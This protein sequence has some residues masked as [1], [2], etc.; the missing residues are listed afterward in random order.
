MAAIDLWTAITADPRW[1]T[2]D[3][4]SVIS[5][6][7]YQR[8]IRFLSPDLQQRSMRQTAVL[9][10]VL[11]MTLNCSPEQLRFGR[12]GRGKPFLPDAPHINF[13]VSHSGPVVLI[14]VTVLKPIGVDVEAIRPMDD[15]ET[16][17]R[18]IFAPGETEAILSVDDRERVLAFFRCWTRKEALVKALGDGLYRD[19]DSFEVSTGP[20][21]VSPLLR[22][23]D[24]DPNEWELHTFWSESDYVAAVAVKSPGSTL[25]M[26]GAPP[27]P[28]S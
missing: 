11:A 6:E 10:L 16:V 28:T 12:M 24:G 2:C 27:V 18:R 26:C 23:D 15:I 8:A 3:C 14:G 7:E 9:R 4:R 5:A 25:R 20:E 21:P 19:L 1:D 17:A 22:L 13:N